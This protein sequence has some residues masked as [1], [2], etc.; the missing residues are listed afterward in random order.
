[1]ASILWFA[2]G[3]VLGAF[4]PNK[5]KPR[6]VAGWVAFRAWVSKPKAP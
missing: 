3:L 6:V 2:A 5:I 4:F 1:M